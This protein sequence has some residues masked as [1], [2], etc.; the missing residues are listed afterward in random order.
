MLIAENGAGWRSQH[1]N[2]AIS[3]KMGVFCRSPHVKHML[4]ELALVNW[5]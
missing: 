3:E 4:G 5:W 1:S 2:I